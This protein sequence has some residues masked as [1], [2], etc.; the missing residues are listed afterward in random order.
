ML[1]PLKK[2]KPYMPVSTEDPLGSTLPALESHHP[3]QTDPYG[4]EATRVG[5]AERWRSRHLRDIQ[6]GKHRGPFGLDILILNVSPSETG[7]LLSERGGALAGGAR[8]LDETQSGHPRPHQSG[9]FRNF[10][11]A[12][13]PSRPLPLDGTPDR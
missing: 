12:R 2:V 1:S 10:T 7:R 13:S 3:R 6:A 11:N 8:H 5:P 9:R 4:N